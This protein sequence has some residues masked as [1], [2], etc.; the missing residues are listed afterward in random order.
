MQSEVRQWQPGE[1][2]EGS[3]NMVQWNAF[4]DQDKIGGVPKQRPVS[5]DEHRTRTKAFFSVG[6]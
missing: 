4:E 5:T 1:V 2:Q 3:K 6:W